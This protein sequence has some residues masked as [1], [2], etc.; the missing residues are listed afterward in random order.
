MILSFLCI[1]IDHKHQHLTA[2][3]AALSVVV[4]PAQVVANAPVAAVRAVAGNLNTRQN[5]ISENERLRS[6]NLRLSTRTQRFA[7]L[8]HE[9]RRLRQLLD[10]SVIFDDDVLV[11]DV[12]AIET[13]PAARQ[14]VV[15]KG[16]NHGVYVGQPLLDAH[17]VIGQVSEVGPFSSTA[18]LI[19]DPR[20]AIPVIVNR[21][22]LRAIA[23]GSNRGDKLELSFVS[24]NADV[25]PGDL[26]VTSGLGRRFPAGYPVGRI[27]SIDTRAGES[28]IEV[29][30]DPSGKV[31]QSREVLLIG[32][33]PIQLDN[34]SISAVTN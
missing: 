9:N 23:V 2:I 8:E 3:R 12:L 11:A 20:H 27:S 32:P 21:N 33:R 7:A 19:T 34:E 10:S 26:V 15:N 1:S 16:S 17:G 31:G 25:A 30:V 14:I 5:L 18:L 29:V 22:G 13:S 28:F 24:T 4:Y 6:E